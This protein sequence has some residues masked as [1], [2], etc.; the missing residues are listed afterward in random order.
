MSHALAVYGGLD[1]MKGEVFTVQPQSVGP[2]KRVAIQ[3]LQAEIAAL[4]QYECTVR[5]YFAD[6]LYVREIHIPAGVVIVGYT[7]RQD[8]I[9]VMVQGVLAIHDG[10]EAVMLQAPKTVPCAKGTKKAGLAIEYTIYLDCYSV[11]DNERDLDRLA[12]RL[13]CDTYEQFVEGEKL[14]LPQ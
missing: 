10:G 7:H 2:E 13:F 14:C 4:P 11:P 3:R 1:P 5:H 6:G 8:C 12:A 9:S